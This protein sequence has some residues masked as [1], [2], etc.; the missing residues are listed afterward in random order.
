M[1]SLASKSA[2]SSS[3]AAGT[4]R[5]E[6]M[7]KHPE[8]L[9]GEAKTP[10]IREV[11]ENEERLRLAE[12]AGQIGTWE[13]DPE[14]D[15]RTLSTELQRIFGVEASDPENARKWAARV[16]PEDWPKVQ[17]LMQQGSQTGKMEF[18]YRYLHPDLGLRWL[19]CKGCRFHDQTRLFGIVQDVTARKA[20]EEASQ[21]LA[22]IVES[23][24][25][26]IISKDLNG[27]ITSWNPGAE[28]MFGF[29]AKEM[30]G[31]PITT[32]IPPQLRDD[33]TR[34][35]ATVGRGESIE[36]FETVRLKKDGDPLD[37]SLTVSPVKDEAGR[38]VGA[39]K[40]ARD[41]TQ[42][43]KA[44]QTL[45][46]TERLAAVGRLAATVAHEIN[47]PL[48]AVTNLIYLAKISP[49]PDEV[50]GFLTTAE[51]QMVCVSHLTRQTLGFYR[52]TTGARM[53]KPSDITDAIVSV[54]ASRAR[55]KGIQLTQQIR[56][57]AVINAVPGEIRQV[58]ANLLSNSVD[59]VQ[60]PGQIRI[61]VSAARQWK[62]GGAS[63]VRITV[64]DTGTGISAATRERMFE[65]FYT[66]KRDVGT[67]LGLWVCKSI[68]ENHRGKLRVHSSTT[69]GKSGT[70]ISV[71]F[72]QNLPK[73]SASEKHVRPE[74]LLGHSC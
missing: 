72:P 5:R 48:E 53:V 38:I 28:R 70:V 3:G 15:T 29:I 25:D 47:N 46:V 6:K 20:A 21:R 31:R 19:F 16:W 57:D 37:V 61:R 2:S 59:A 73:E 33:E 42:R 44:E 9:Q 10:Q 12:A 32:I 39:A 74:G 34:I 60:G 13:W 35:L 45:L 24:D 66:T 62:N 69:P 68:V 54:F 67:G 1:N 51:E 41:I 14:H 58:V 18:E 56:S 65:P 8:S 49:N 27:V 64:A 40:I 63:G 52:E 23:S 17:S 26:A 30:I 50:R 71:F 43:K 4:V 36:H 55:N 22:A 7:S 11:E